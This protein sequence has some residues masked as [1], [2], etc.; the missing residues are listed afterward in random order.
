MTLIPPNNIY[1]TNNY[2]ITKDAPTQTPQGLS[3]TPSQLN[4]TQRHQ[5]RSADGCC[6]PFF[7]KI[8]SF[9]RWL[10]PCLFPTQRGPLSQAILEQRVQFGT[11]MI[12]SQL[13]L[14]VENSPNNLGTNWN[15]CGIHQDLI[16]GSKVVFTLEYNGNRKIFL[17]ELNGLRSLESLKQTA[18]QE[19][20]TH[21]RNSINDS[22]QQAA[23]AIRTEIYSQYR[24]RTCDQMPIY[25]FN[26]QSKL[27][28]L[29][30]D[31]TPIDGS[32]HGSDGS[33]SGILRPEIMDLYLGISPQDLQRI[34]QF[35]FPGT[36]T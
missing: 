6:N 26:H 12:E 27:L 22:N 31:N 30:P 11:N 21:I 1:S 5:A 3:N 14:R 28:S 2:Q 35:L 25:S 24:V 29:H 33:T 19:M 15:P 23:F 4:S 10:L 18:L 9:L 17:A 36:S 20:Q 7:N 13:R 32:F 16:N 34:Q 8:L